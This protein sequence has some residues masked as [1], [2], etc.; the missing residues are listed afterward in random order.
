M[1]TRFFIYAHFFRNTTGAYKKALVY[2]DFLLMA[3][4]ILLD[5][6]ILFIDIFKY[7]YK[8]CMEMFIDNCHVQGEGACSGSGHYAY[9]TLCCIVGGY[10]VTITLLSGKLK[11]SILFEMN[12]GTNVRN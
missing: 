3:V 2:L 1:R 9:I 8:F 12:K 7:I 10:H 11:E 6:E 4:I 5:C